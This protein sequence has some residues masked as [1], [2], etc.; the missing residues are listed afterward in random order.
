MG[1]FNLKKF[2]IK[3]S[4]SIG[5]AANIRVGQLLGANKPAE[6]KNAYRVAYTM[7]SIH[8]LIFL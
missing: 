2:S 6:A 5:I 8:N 3:F 1:A 4:F 7:N